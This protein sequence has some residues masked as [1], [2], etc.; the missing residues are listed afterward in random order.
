MF[1]NIGMYDVVMKI[2]YGAF[3]AIIYPLM[4]SV[5][6]MAVVRKDYL[7]GKTDCHYC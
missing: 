2:G 7:T 4:I 1:R 3:A 5:I 6:V